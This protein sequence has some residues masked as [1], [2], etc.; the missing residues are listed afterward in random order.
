M[1]L[2][3][4]RAEE[5]TLYPRIANRSVLDGLIQTATRM[6]DPLLSKMALSDVPLVVIG[7]PDI[8]GVSFVDVDNRAGA[9]KVA[10]HLHEIGRRRIAI[11]GAP[12]DTTAGTDRLAGFVDGL[13]SC[14]AELDPALRVDGDFSEASGYQAMNRLLPHR[15]DAVFAASDTMAFGALR[16]LRQHGLRV[17]DDIAAGFEGW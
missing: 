6:G 17:P 4:N 13:A 5:E 9:F 2:F 15:P 8:E 7:R 10:R 11:V 14:G 1:F 3:E 12:T 16:S